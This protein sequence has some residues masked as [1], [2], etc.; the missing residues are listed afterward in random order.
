MVKSGTIYSRGLTFPD[1]MNVATMKREIADV[2]NEM[3]ED[4]KKDNNV[5][6]DDGLNITMHPH[7]GRP[8]LS[9]RITITV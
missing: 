6:N 4:M 5:F 2:I 7:R 3:A 1:T 8:N 9:V